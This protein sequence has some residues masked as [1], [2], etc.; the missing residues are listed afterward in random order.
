MSE[1]SSNVRAI[2]E[3]GTISRPRVEGE[4][5]YF[6]AGFLRLRGLPDAVCAVS[7]RKY[8]H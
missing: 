7:H 3:Q 4:H 8:R 2:G 6:L 1:M 5:R